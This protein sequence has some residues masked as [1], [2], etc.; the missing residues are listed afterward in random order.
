[1][2]GGRLSFLYF[3]CRLTGKLQLKSPVSGVENDSTETLSRSRY[4]LPVLEGN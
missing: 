2:A 1:M 3:E 4:Y